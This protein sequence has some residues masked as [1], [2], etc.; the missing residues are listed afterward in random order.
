VLLVVG[1]G[2][3]ALSAAMATS[4]SHDSRKGAS[5]PP[6]STVILTHARADLTR[7]QAGP[8]LLRE[9]AA[10][11]LGTPVQD[12]AVTAV[13]GGVMLLAGLTA[14]DTSRSDVAFA[15]VGGDRLL[16]HLPGALHDAAAVT[17]GRSAYL[18]G[19]GDVSQTATIQRVDPASGRSATAGQLPQPA[20]DVAA[21]ALG[22]TA[23]VVG[24][25]TGSRWLDTI[26]AW[27]PGARARVVGRLPQPVRYA[28]VAAAGGQLVIA[29]GSLPDG[30]ASSAVLVWRPGEPQARLLGRLPAATT[31]AAAATLGGIAY[32]IGGRS[33]TLD[34][35]TARVVAVD[36]ATR[37]V[38]AAG[39]LLE[40]RSDLGA[41]PVGRGILLVGGRTPAGTTQALGLLQP[42]GSAAHTVHTAHT[43]HTASAAHALSL[44]PATANVYAN[45]APGDLSPAVRGDLQRIY[46]PNSESN[47][48]DVI[49]PHT[50]RIVGHFAVG[51]LPQHVTPSYDLKTLYVDNDLGNS[52]TPLDPRTGK[53]KGPPIPVDDPY[54]LYFTP[55]GQ[56]AI[57]VAERL[58]R[59]DFR[60]AHSFRLHHSLSVPCKG[61]DHMDFTADGRYLLASCEFAGRLIVVDVQRE[62]LVRTIDLPSG[63]GMPQDVKLSPD[64]RL[65]YVADMVA[66]GLWEVSARTFRVVGF[67]RTG[68]GVHG[69]YPS[70]D[71]RYL[72]ATN[73]GEGSIS[74]ISFRTHKQVAKWWIGGSPDMGGVSADGRTLWLSG[75]YNGVVYAVDTRTG[76]LRA[77]IPVGVGPHGLCVWP[78]PGR[79]SLG[80]TGE[81]R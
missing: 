80:H 19:G 12:A 6:G 75:R 77:T 29:G 25:F 43:T 33:A 62:R 46:V 74:V 65:F 24:G 1:G 11:R 49:D 50:Y 13:P 20:S 69:L 36:P 44:A 55:G 3:V 21:A 56:Y 40:P 63:G 8:S 34:T 5:D 17:L 72:Y 38:Q 22:G 14:A 51:T 9:H 76:K 79:Y 48:V 66:G 41:A 73:R 67:L 70:R 78:Q 61:V 31:H 30:T 60:D 71:A 42:A 81:L 26:V 28:A 47:T 27:R 58:E 10:G 53:P 23:Y 18:F 45:D 39:R 64:G 15:H 35:P 7:P 2:L 32:V 59:L 57:V 52:L 37:R 4:G 16:S 68:R 54:N